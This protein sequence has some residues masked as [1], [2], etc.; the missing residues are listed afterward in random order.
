ML[1][2]IFLM[3][4]LTRDPELRRTGS[5]VAN[6]TFS[7]A[8]DRDYGGKNGGEKKT[9]FIDCVAWRNT[10]EFLEKYFS[11][12]RM[13]V[14]E[15]R[16]ETQE[17]EKDGQKHRKMLVV[18]ENCYFGDSKRDNNT[19]NGGSYDA[20]NGGGFA[21]SPAGNPGYAAPAP[22]G[23]GYAA[24]APAGGGYAAPVPNGGGYAAPAPNG[25]G[26]AT[27]A[28]AGYGSGYNPAPTPNGGGYYPAPAGGF[29]PMGG[30][31]PSL[32]F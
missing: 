19:T 32:P 8:V 3:G 5:G 24:P 6:T 18:V 15:G 13:V 21:P 31:D 16:L 9:D 22:A 26:Y 1:N 29:S 20:P 14:V 2:S 4:R 30:D 7:L 27:P 11:K 28:S 23:G 10:A 25:G 17:W 12:G